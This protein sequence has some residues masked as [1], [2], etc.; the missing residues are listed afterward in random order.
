MF[1]NVFVNFG[2]GKDYEF[3]FEAGEPMGRAMEDARHWLDEQYVKLECEPVN[4]MGKTLIIDKVLIIAKAVGE[5]PFAGNDPWAQ[6][7]ARSAALALGRDTVRIDVAG[8]T[9][10]H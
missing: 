7:F 6:Q 9:V 8:F 1:Y 10:G 2:T 3:Q 5:K 4:P